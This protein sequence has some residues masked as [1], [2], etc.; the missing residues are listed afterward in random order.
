MDKKKKELDYIPFCNP[1]KAG[2]PLKFTPIELAEKFD[3]FVKW[4]QTHPIKV[5]KTSTTTGQSE[6]KSVSIEE[7]PRL[8]SVI[9][10][11]NWLG[12]TK[13]WW[14]ELS[15]GKYGA[16]FSTL[17]DNITQYCFEYQY[18]AASSWQYN[19]NIVARYLGLADKQETT[20]KVVWEMQDPNA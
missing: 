16:E 15:D 14:T 7:R 1:Y 2:R 8:V 4:A 9:Q 19:P 11:L 6:V 18:E 10:F 13:R 3:E 5:R 12:M 17:K 20:E